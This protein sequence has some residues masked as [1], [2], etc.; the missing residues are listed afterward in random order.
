MNDTHRMVVILVSG[1][2]FIGK[3][4]PFGGI[5]VVGEEC[6]SFDPGV[7][8]CQDQFVGIG[9]GSMVETSSSTDDEFATPDALA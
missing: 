9:E 6:G 1:E 7:D 3:S 4:F 2:R 8:Q 5:F